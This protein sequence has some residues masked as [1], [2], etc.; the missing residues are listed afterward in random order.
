MTEVSLLAGAHEPS[1]P[2]VVVVEDDPGLQRQMKWALADVF[3]VHTASDRTAALDLVGQHA[4]SLMV[5]DLGLPPDPNG[6]SEGLMV[7]ETVIAKNPNI[8]II[9]A[10]GNEERAN[11]LRAVSLGA[12]DFFAK[13]VD[14]DELRLTLT[15]A[16]RFRELE[17]ENR[18]LSQYVH[19]PLDGIIS[20]SPQMLSVCETV[21]R[22]AGADVSVLVL[23]ESGTG[24]ELI[25]RAL[26]ALGERANGPFIATNCAAIPETLLES[27]LFG[28]ER[29]AFTG[30]VKRTI[31]RI[32]AAVGGTLFLDE[33]G[34]MPFPLQAKLLRFLQDRTIQRLGSQQSI[35]VQVRVVS[36][37]NK[38]LQAMIAAGSFREDLYFRLNEIA[39]E[40]P[41]LR[42][43]SEDAVMI[44]N[45]L[46]R[47]YAD[48]YKRPNARL[49]SG[50]L[51]A[52]ANYA[53]PGN[54]RELENKMKRAILM[55]KQDRIA[56]EDL[57]LSGPEGDGA[58][59]TLKEARSRAESDLIRKVLAAHRNNMS[60][61][62][63]VLGISRPT[64]YGLMASHGIKAE[65]AGE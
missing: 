44:A 45:A 24:K 50:A 29:G 51:A 53:W 38:N 58:F 10:S 12:Y 57:G 39:V 55:A 3:T 8:K 35:P 41:P 30:A 54:V 43:R 42:E 26:H 40:L 61:A 20:A 7:L 37:T 17:E 46:A 52:I 15:R 18:R 19:N 47:R 32:E 34:D 1:L 23:G 6:A 36:A 31:G 62:A 27:E 65:D 2:V 22:V 25:A 28:Y 63:K 5:L 16:S 13:P 64:L 9:V 4:P 33:I 60:Q 11:A 59:P 21:Q 48:V 56:A 49:T 14:F